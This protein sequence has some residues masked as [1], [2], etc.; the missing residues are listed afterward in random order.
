MASAAVAVPASRRGLDARRCHLENWPVC[1][2]SLPEPLPLGVDIGAWEPGCWEPPP[3]DLILGGLSA[4]GTA[5]LP[6]VTP[7]GCE[8]GGWACAMQFIKGCEMCLCTGTWAAPFT[9]ETPSRGRPPGPSSRLLTCSL[10]PLSPP[11]A[12][13]VPEDFLGPQAQPAAD[14]GVCRPCKRLSPRSRRP[15][16][17]FCSQAPVLTSPEAHGPRRPPP[18]CPTERRPCLTGPCSHPWAPTTDSSAASVPLSLPGRWRASPRV[19]TPPPVSPATAP[20]L[21]APTS[22]SDAQ[23][24]TGIY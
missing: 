8:P 5:L 17:T 18:S 20:L 13:L 19:H 12:E 1:A 11:Q 24:D 15:A 4:E 9:L 14:A 6:L 3:G 7:D 22:T 10:H 16:P 23:D 2:S 21:L